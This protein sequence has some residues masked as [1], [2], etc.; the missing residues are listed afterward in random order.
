MHIVY[1]GLSTPD[2]RPRINAVSLQAAANTHI[3]QDTS[4]TA[5]ERWSS[6][7]IPSTISNPIHSQMS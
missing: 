6:Q 5:H 7:Q 2:I 4:A 3:R 1:D